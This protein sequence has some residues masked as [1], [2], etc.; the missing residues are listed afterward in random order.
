MGA[1]QKEFQNCVM[2]YLSYMDIRIETRPLKGEIFQSALQ[3]WSD[4]QCVLQNVLQ[5]HFGSGQQLNFG[6]C[7]SPFLGLHTKADSVGTNWAL[8][9]QTK[10][11]DSEL[12][13]HT[14]AMVFRPWDQPGARPKASTTMPEVLSAGPSATSAF[15]HWASPLCVLS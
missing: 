8:L 6:S 7:H 15:P 14:S 11:K 5:Q 1:F 3:A 13:S 10:L 12:S 4:F 9:D 2:G